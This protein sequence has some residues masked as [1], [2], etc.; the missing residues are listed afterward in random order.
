V[1]GLI[2][3]KQEEKMINI[4][5]EFE[6]ARNLYKQQEYEETSSLTTCI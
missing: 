4:K 6:K 2:L 1:A 5:D 3:I